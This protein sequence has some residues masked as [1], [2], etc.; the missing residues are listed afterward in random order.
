MK[1]FSRVRQF[2]LTLIANGH[3]M[4]QQYLLILFL[5]ITS[6]DA[7]LALKLCRMK[8]HINSEKKISLDIEKKEIFKSMPF[9]PH[10]K[11]LKKESSEWENWLGLILNFSP[12]RKLKTQMSKSIGKNLDGVNHRVEAHITILTPPI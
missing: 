12:F 10:G 2:K 5:S 3:F 7:A 4:W 8:D 6:F 11:Y 1:N 9:I